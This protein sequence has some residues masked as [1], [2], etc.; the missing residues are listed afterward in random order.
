MSECTTEDPVITLTLTRPDDEELEA[1][2]IGPTCGTLGG[3][4]EDPVLGE[5]W[6]NQ[7]TWPDFT[8]RT[9]TAPPS[10]WIPGEQ[11]LA[12][13][14]E[15]GSIQAVVV[16]RGLSTADVLV[17]QALL[18]DTL[19]QWAYTATITIG[20]DDLGTWPAKPTMPV[21]GAIT[22]QLSGLFV[23]QGACVIRVNPTGAP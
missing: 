9:T 13:V 18:A 7:L 1:L 20:D 6:W 2:V 14:P 8:Y 16:A 21:W 12:A 15:A 17:Q 3:D 23:A 10:M 19:A 11:V 4:E 5:L 22:P